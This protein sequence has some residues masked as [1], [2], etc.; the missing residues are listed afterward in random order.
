MVDD[1]ADTGGARP[2][3]VAPAARP[4]AA[5]ALPDRIAF[6]GLG[7]IG[8]SI[9][10]AVREAGYRGTLAAWTPSGRGPGEGLR[11]GIVDVA[12]PEPASA[13]DGAGLVILAGPPLA[14]LAALSDLAGPL[15]RHLGGEATLTDV[16]S[17]KALVVQN[18]DAYGL[19]FVG[20]HPMAGRETTGVGSASPDL[21]LD[22]PWVV[23]PGSSARGTDVERVGTLAAATG[24]RAVRLEAAEHDAA[25]AAI[26]HL[27]LVLAAALVEAVAGAR[28]GDAAGW[29]IARQ[30]AA[31]GWRDM[32]RLAKGDPEM[33]AGILST[34]APAVRDRLRAF[35][36]V[37]D[38]WIE[39]LDAGQ[40]GGNAGV[41]WGRLHAA[42]EALEPPAA[43]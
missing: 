40:G 20:G 41:L 6:L 36:D 8:G 11:R 21:F 7:L 23:V 16:A 17:T 24:A 15:R 28:A 2:E 34:N 9:A 29:P 14:V 39:E 10:M 27:P 31:S 5:A 38:T 19:P 35:R 22:R 32:T 42:R 4:T 12:A 43:E 13:L 25:V 1:A 30:L 3:A 26:S 33:G 37:L 18:A